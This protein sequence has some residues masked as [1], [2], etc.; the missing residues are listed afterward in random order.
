MT[1]IIIVYSLPPFWMQIKRTDIKSSLNDSNHSYIH[2]WGH[3][4]VTGKVRG[5]V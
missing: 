3:I 5:L 4:V 1:V 2:F